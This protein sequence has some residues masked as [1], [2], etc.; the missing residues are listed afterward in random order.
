M[1]G[2]SNWLGNEEVAK[3]YLKEKNNLQGKCPYYISMY[4][5]RGIWS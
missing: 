2:G 3:I 5:H 4:F 1:N